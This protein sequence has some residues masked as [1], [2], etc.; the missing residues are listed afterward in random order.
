M[1]KPFLLLCVVVTV[2]FEDDTIEVAEGAGSVEVCVNAS[3]AATFDLSLQYTP[4]TA[5]GENQN[6]TRIKYSPIITKH[7]SCTI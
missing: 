1:H 7:S 3:D 5:Q 2:G 6:D 4:V